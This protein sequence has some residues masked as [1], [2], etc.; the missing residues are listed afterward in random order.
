MS[1]AAGPFGPFHLPQ[2]DPIKDPAMSNQILVANLG[3]QHVFFGLGS[4][5]RDGTLTPTPN[6][7]N[8]DS[9]WSHDTMSVAAGPFHPPQ[10]DPIKDAAMSNQI[11]AANLGQQQVLFGLGLVGSLAL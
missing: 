9:F 8:T 1:V 7:P 10:M 3:Q 5:E 6:W 4:V 11:L 2:M